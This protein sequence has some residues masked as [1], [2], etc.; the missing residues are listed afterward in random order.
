MD[1]HER[2]QKINELKLKYPEFGKA[3]AIHT[4]CEAARFCADIT[5]NPS[6]DHELGQLIGQIEVELYDFYYEV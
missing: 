5:V 4:M 1:I 3:Y 2:I 6:M